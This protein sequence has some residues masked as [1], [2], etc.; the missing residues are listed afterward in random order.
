MRLTYI[1]RSIN[2]WFVRVVYQRD[3]W[4]EWLESAADGIDIRI[5]WVIYI[6]RACVW[7]TRKILW[8]LMYLG[9]AV[10]GFMLRQMEF[11]ADSY[12]AR[13]AGS[14]AFESTARR[15]HLLGL[16]WHNA[17]SDLAS[18]HRE[19]RLVDDLPK[20]MLANLKQ[21]PKEAHDFV[22]KIIAESKTGV[23]DDH[24]SDQQ[25][26]LAAHALAAPGVFHTDLPAQMLFG[27][28]DA[29]AKGVTWDYYCSIFGKLVDPKS[30]H[31]TDQLIARTEGDQA[32]SKA[33]D[34][35][36]AGTFS[37]L[38]PLRLPILQVE[39]TQQ[40]AAW[41][42]ELNETRGAMESQAIIGR[43][44]LA[45]LDKSDTQLV[46]SRQAR[47]VLAAGVAL[48]ANRF[49]AAYRSVA[50]ASRLR[51]AAQTELSRLGNRLESFEEAAGR[52]LRANL[53]LLSQ[54]GISGR[55][56]GG[57]E[58]HQE[59][60]RLWPVV[61]Q[62]SSVHG[63]I[64]ELR[65]SNATLAALLGHFQGNERNESLAREILDFA[66]RVR[67]Q[68]ADLKS[69]FERVDY[70]FDH[71]AGQI[72]V[73]QFLIKVVPPAEEI[74][75]IHEAADE[76]VNKLLEMYGRA[77]SR[78]CVIAEAVETDQGLSPLAMSEEAVG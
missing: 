23:F 40:A 12:E 75:A 68:V 58:M 11:D 13:V 74:G 28:F 38:R 61:S 20:L 9:H 59:C 2:F 7:L 5:G 56:Q 54:P 53:M 57:D 72:S 49:E 25:R 66:A 24:P 10:A 35:F 50:D 44:L 43:E 60:G 32:A 67:T 6:A 37:F 47:S 62:I 51:D 73:S 4:D 1:I 48:Q 33:R 34:R 30:L 8:A 29:L 17:Q 52:R 16:A 76:T 78:L 27:N 65:N 63:S 3:A 39:K 31:S 14:D 77:V 26:I 21:L 45:A 36:F 71:A 19:G 70:P 46:Q 15:L 55:M 22:G 41:L 69:I 18:F 42:T 64:L